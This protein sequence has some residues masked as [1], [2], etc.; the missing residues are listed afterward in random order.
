MPRLA[1]DSREASLRKSMIKAFP[2]GFSTRYISS[3][4][5]C[6]SVK[7]LNAARHSKK[8]NDSS[9]TACATHFPAENQSTRQLY[10]AFSRAISN[11][12]L[13]DVQ[14]GY[15]I[16]AEFRQ[17]DGEISWP[18]GNFQHAGLSRDLLRP[19]AAPTRQ[20][21]PS[22]SGQPGIPSG[23]RAFHS[24]T[25]I[26]F[27]CGYVNRHK[28]L[29]VNPHRSPLRNARTNGFRRIIYTKSANARSSSVEE[30]SL[31]GHRLLSVFSPGMC[32]NRSSAVSSVISWPSRSPPGSGRRDPCTRASYRIR[33][34]FSSPTEPPANRNQSRDFSNQLS[35]IRVNFNPSSLTT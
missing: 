27:F 14:A 8:S 13:A 21:L 11:K 23:H 5:R 18:W 20:I 34:R 22:T 35:K 29:L 9:Q 25:F 2:P 6:G 32:N 19:R 4:A 12:R 24:P 31:P 10:L 33:E 7:F 17:F 15:L 1:L 30:L 28:N 3:N 16:F 26:A